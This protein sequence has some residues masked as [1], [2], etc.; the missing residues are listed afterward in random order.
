MLCCSGLPRTRGSLLAIPTPFLGL[1][2]VTAHFLGGTGLWAMPGMWHFSRGSCIAAVSVGL[3]AGL[4][5]WPCSEPPP[6]QI[7]T[8]FLLLHGLVCPPFLSQGSPEITES[9]R[10]G[11][12]S[13]TS[14]IFATNLCP[15][16]PHPRCFR[17][18]AVTAL[19]PWAAC[20]DA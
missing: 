15:Q 12:T 5:S 7:C 19:L 2:P 13:R 3:S 4:R 11:K 14:T 20:P 16:V 17:T 6:W 1:G 8:C 18:L 9:L 10:L